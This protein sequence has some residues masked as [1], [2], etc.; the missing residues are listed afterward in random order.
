MTHSC[1]PKQH[2]VVSGMS[3]PWCLRKEKATKYF[4]NHSH[5]ERSCMY[6]EDP[7]SAAAT[8]LQFWWNN[9]NNNDKNKTTTTSNNKAGEKPFISIFDFRF[10][11]DLCF[12]ALLWLHLFSLHN[13]SKISLFYPP[14]QIKPLHVN[15]CQRISLTLTNTTLPYSLLQWLFSY[16]TSPGSQVLLNTLFSPHSCFGGF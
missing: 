3:A 4:Y 12:Q 9:D 16:L 14:M 7:C 11:L 15:Y 6:T 8:V 1:R 5:H 10:S 13:T 2:P